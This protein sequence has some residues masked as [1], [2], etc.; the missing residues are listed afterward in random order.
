[1][2]RTKLKCAAV[3]DPGRVRRNNEDAYYLDGDRG[4]FLVVDGIGGQAAGEKAAEIAVDRVRARLERQTGTAEQRVREAIAMANNEILRAARGNPEWKGMACVLTVVAMDNGSAVAGHVGDSRLYEIRGRQI[5]KITHDHSPVGQREDAGELTESEAMRH[6]RR[7]EVF[8]DVGSEE[9]EPGDPDFIEIVRFPFDPDSALLLCSDGLS[10]LVASAEIRSAVA[11]NPGNPEKAARELVEAAN[12]AGGKDNVT[13]VIVEG[14]QFQ[15][16]P[17]EA[18]VSVTSQRK[19]LPWI[20][21]LMIGAALGFGADRF[22]R[23]PT[24]P[25]PVIEPRVLAVGPG[26]AFTEIG[27]AVTQ[28]KPGDIVEVAAGEYREQVTLKNGVTLRSRVPLEAILR[29]APLSTGPAVI[30]NGVN[31]ARLHGFRIQAD[32]QSPISA[33]I[34]LRNSEVEVYD[35][36]ISGAGV[37]IELRGGG[38]VAL[39]GNTIRECAA[40]GVLVSGSSTPWISHNALRR[41]KG[42]GVAAREGARPSLVDNIF[43]KNGIDVPPDMLEA[44][45]AHNILL[46]AARP[47][48]RPAAPLRKQ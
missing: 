32:A 4:I 48:P 20:L 33:A 5:R 31:G 14:D 38:G 15:G 35:T 11:R 37:G 25:P 12:R 7:N 34:V 44:V 2:V 21:G 17:V 28:A 24:P 45:R 10:D 26:Q 8:R 22:L 29:A 18:V 40:E 41:N 3:S 19:W 46:D 42:A 13:V 16:D 1:M 30:A 27:S 6:P 23:K 43:E 9:H 39:V 47:A 36:E